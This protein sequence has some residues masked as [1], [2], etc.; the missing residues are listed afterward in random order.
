MTDARLEQLRQITGKSILVEDL[1]DHIDDLRRQLETAK[2]ERDEAILSSG[3]NRIHASVARQELAKI[4]GER[5]KLAARAETLE[6]EGRTLHYDLAMAKSQLEQ[7]Q[8]EIARLRE[9]V[10]RLSK[11]ADGVPMTEGMTAWVP[12]SAGVIDEVTMMTA[13]A[14]NAIGTPFPAEDC[15]STRDAAEKA[16]DKQV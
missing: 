1:V 5:D 14:M 2:T 9:I 12:K 8:A 13:Y 16:K 7:A 6:C 4:I 10:E 3:S 11:T 15:Y